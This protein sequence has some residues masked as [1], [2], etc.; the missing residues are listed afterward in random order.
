MSEKVPQKRYG[1][2]VLAILLLLLGGAALYAGSH[3][4]MT[5]SFGLMAV[6]AGVYLVR[7]SSVH[8]RSGLST[9]SGRGLDFASNPRPGHL[10][11]L[12]GVALLLLAGL[13]FFYLYR[14]ALHGYHEALPVYAFAGVTVACAVV[15]SYLLSR[16]N[17]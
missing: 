10:A 1:L 17:R 15:W 16:I 6:L 12:I 7:L 11:W 5:R 9:A 3:N 4:F 13:S 8:T 2:L 14:D